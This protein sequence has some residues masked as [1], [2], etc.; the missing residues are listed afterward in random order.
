MKDYN[1]EVSIISF[2]H[3][4]KTIHFYL[5]DNKAHFSGVSYKIRGSQSYTGSLCM[6]EKERENY[7]KL[8]E[9]AWSEL[10]TELAKSELNLSIGGSR[11]RI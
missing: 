8:A 9:V 1:I 10:Q 4:D 7:Q 3:N 5:H 11:C 2:I 6:D